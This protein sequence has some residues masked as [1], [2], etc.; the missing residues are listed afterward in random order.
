MYLSVSL[1]TLD[2]GR[3]TIYFFIF[4]SCFIGQHNALQT[5]DEQM[6]DADFTSMLHHIHSAVWIIFKDL[7]F[8]LFVCFCFSQFYSTQLAEK[9]GFKIVVRQVHDSVC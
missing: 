2:L 1:P 9:H 5:F 6:Q 3:E 7:F 8:C 4:Y